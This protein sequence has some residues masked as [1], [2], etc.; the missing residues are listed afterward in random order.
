MSKKFPL[1]DSESDQDSSAGQAAGLFVASVGKAFAVLEA[2]TSTKSE[3]SLTEVAQ[4]TGIGRSA[5]QRFLFTLSTLGYLIQDSHGK[6]LYRLS[7]KLF[8]LTQSYSN[9]DFLK[10]KASPI[11][12][13]ANAA[14]E[15]TINLTL[16]DGVNVVYVLR[17]PSKHVVSVNLTVGAKLPAYCTAPGRA[18]LAHLPAQEADAILASSSLVKMTN[19]TETNPD[20]LRGILSDVRRDGFALSNQEAFIGDISVAAPVLDERSVPIAAVNIAVPSPRWSVDEVTAKLIPLVKN[21]AKQISAG[22]GR[23]V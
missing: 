17:F 5:A 6:R 19:A 16:L 15:E 13:A 22:A 21:T 9:L 7:P 10:E 20:K 12:E 14:C 1:N 3:L 8:T 4:L 11:L 2:F 18:I 23:Q